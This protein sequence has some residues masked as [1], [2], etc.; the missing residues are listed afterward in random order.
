MVSTSLTFILVSIA[1]TANSALA[2][3]VRGARVAS[4][5][6]T[7]RKA[8]PVTKPHAPVKPAAKTRAPTT[9]KTQSKPAAGSIP[10]KLARN[11]PTK[12]GPNWWSTA[13]SDVRNVAKG[14]KTAAGDVKNVANKA[15]PVAK[16]AI[17]FAS[18]AMPLVKKAAPFV[19]KVAPVVAK[20]IPIAEKVLPVAEELALILRR[21]EEGL[22]E[23]DG[24]EEDQLLS[25]RE[26]IELD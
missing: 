9:S 4:A 3:P 19:E 18:K 5:S 11:P 8:A 22:T 12:P 24:F 16:D 17:D 26:F 23:R 20:A 25:S 15:I 6:T 10:K 1:L 7:T 13:V 21:E 2:I 14:A